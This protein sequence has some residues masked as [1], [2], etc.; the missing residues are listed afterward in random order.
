MHDN[1][2]VYIFSHGNLRIENNTLYLENENIIEKFS[3]DRTDEIYILGEVS[4]NGEFLKAASK[5]KIIMHFFNYYGYYSGTFFPREHRSTPE[6]LFKQTECYLNNYKRLKIAMLFVEG[7]VLN[8]LQVMRYYKNRGKELGQIEERIIAL[9]GLIKK[10]SN[11]NELMAIEG[12]VRNYYYQAFDKILDNSDFKFEQRS[13][14]PPKNFLNTLISFGNSMLYTT[15]LSQIYFTHLDPRIGYL[16]TSNFRRFSLNLDLAEIFKPIIVDRVIFTVINRNIITANDFEY[17]SEGVMLKEKGK[18][19]F[20]N[21]FE[22]KMNSVISLTDTK[23]KMSYKNLI[24]REA[25]NLEGYLSHGI[26]YKPFA[27]RW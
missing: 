11:I 21:N 22:D 17:L 19:I 26:E 3:I 7:A 25:E 24:Q 4:I 5:R 18:K 6:L 8:I 2:K 15:I 14:R 23:D 16:H 1:K 9:A 27:V 12:N 20:V 10:C 13:K